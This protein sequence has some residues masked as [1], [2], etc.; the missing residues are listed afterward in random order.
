MLYAG[1][2]D[3]SYAEN[4]AR[5]IRGDGGGAITVVRREYSCVEQV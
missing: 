1:G 2:G 4:S 3:L 5:G